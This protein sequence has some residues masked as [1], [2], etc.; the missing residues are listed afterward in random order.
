M[1]GV[2]CAITAR[3]MGADVSMNIE[4][5]VGEGFLRQSSWICATLE[6]GAVHQSREVAS[7]L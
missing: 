3:W 5:L 2:Q 6:Y 1:E 7:R 4:M